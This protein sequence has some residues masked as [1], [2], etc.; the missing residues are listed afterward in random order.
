[1]LTQM[2]E[3]RIVGNILNDCFEAL[4]LKDLGSSVM[5]L[6]E[7]LFDTS[8]SLLYRCDNTGKLVKFG[9]TMEEAH[10][11]YT[12]L[13]YSSD[14]MQTLLRRLNL[15]ITN[16]PRYPE[17]KKFLRLPVYHDHARLH[18]V[19]NYIHIRLNEFGHHEPGMAGMLF[20]RSARQPQF[21]DH[22]ELIL[23][24]VLPALESLTR[25]DA[26]I[27]EQLRSHSFV[28]IMLD[29]DLRPKIALDT[30]G[31]LLWASERAENLL[32][33]RRGK[34][35]V[36][37]DV[38]VKAARQLGA[39]TGTNPIT[40]APPSSIAI[41]QEQGT[42][43]RA[44]LRLARTRTGSPFVVAEL[45]LTYATPQLTD[46]A[47]RFQLTTTETQ[48]LGLLAKGLSD[49]E[50]SRHLFVSMATVR[51]HVGHIL[52]KLGVRS[53]VQAALLAHGHQLQPSQ[54]NE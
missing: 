44:E 33:L 30:S 28:E 45:D 42:P 24:R 39:L 14:P 43:I 32:K 36:L 54:E 12:D 38:L 5:P 53:R 49:Q 52:D 6:F 23:A 7:D 3:E 4:T 27:E 35:Q 50:I 17:W 21:N 29:L 26:R 31:K 48:V 34:R 25:R 13:Y 9:G 47:D 51:T 10:Y 46:A 22:D 1:M 18:E 11:R 8:N 37:P 20:A 40:I 16:G 15:W 19:D 2:E 41:P